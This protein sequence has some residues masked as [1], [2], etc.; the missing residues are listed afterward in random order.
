MVSGR[1]TEIASDIPETRLG[2]VRE[3][4]QLGD[5]VV[6]PAPAVLNFAKCRNEAI[7]SLLSMESFTSTKTRPLAARL[8]KAGTA[9]RPRAWR[10]PHA[11]GWSGV[12]C[13]THN[14]QWESRVQLVL[15]IT[16]YKYS[17]ITCSRTSN[18]YRRVS[19]W[20]PGRYPYAVRYFTPSAWAF[21]RTAPHDRPA[22]SS[23]GQASL[24]AQEVSSLKDK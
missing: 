2:A 10:S 18:R 3:E 21:F 4:A 11:R 13:G 15:V 5:E 14:F 19:G 7:A 6:G 16:N 23:P 9:A 24:L 1:A 22:P 17:V 20:K 8:G 12:R